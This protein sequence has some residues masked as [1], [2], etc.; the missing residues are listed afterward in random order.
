[1]GPEK[2]SYE[3]NETSPRSEESPRSAGTPVSESFES[4]TPNATSPT[5]QDDLAAAEERAERRKPWKKRKR[6]QESELE[7]SSIEKKSKG[8]DSNESPDCQNQQDATC[9]PN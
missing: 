4:T 8:E 1:M 2:E 6:V 5:P 7:D 9:D 3:S